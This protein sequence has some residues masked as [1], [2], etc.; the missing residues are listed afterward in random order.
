MSLR[1]APSRL[2]EYLIL[3]LVVFA[4]LLT[5]SPSVAEVD[6]WGHIQY[7]R[8]VLEG[9]LP[10]STT[11][12][13]TAAGFPWINHEN[14][15]EIALAWTADR[16]GNLGLLVGKMLL[17]LLIIGIL[18]GYNL[19]Q[20]NGWVASSVITLLVA[21]NLGFHFSLRPQVAS[22]VCFTF[23]I[24]IL[25]IAFSGWRDRWWATFSRMPK[26]ESRTPSQWLN[27]QSARLK[28]LWLIPWIM[29]IW[30]N[31]HG[32]FPA[33]LLIF[34]VYLGVRGLEAAW[35]CGWA[36]AG[37]LRRLALMGLAAALATT[38]NPYSYQ[39]HLWLWEAV[40]Y[41][42][43]E[44]SDWC[45][46]ELW[47]VTGFKFWLLLGVALVSLIASRR[48]WDVAQT[49][50]LAAVLC[51]ALLHFRHVPFFAILCG[52]W[53]GPHLRAA[54]DRLAPGQSSAS[55]PPFRFERFRTPLN[56]ALVGCGIWLCTGLAGRLNFLPVDKTKFPVAAFQFMADH[57]LNGRMVVTYDWAQYALYAFCT[58]DSLTG[59]RGSVSF[60]GRYR[61]CYPYELCD[62]HFD[63][64]FGNRPGVPRFRHPRSLPAD[65]VRIL[66]IGDPELV[67]NRR[68][69]E[70]TERVMRG[71]QQDWVLLYQDA[72]AQVWGRRSIYDNPR[73]A[74]YLAPSNRCIHDEWDHGSVAWP[75]LPTPGRR[76]WQPADERSVAS[77]SNAKPL[78]DLPDLAS[79]RF[80]E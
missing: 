45:M 25:Q 9:G 3:A 76:T 28:W 10:T 6:L 34:L 14:L 80:Q 30:A 46:N 61:T 5:I 67:I 62:Y 39:M 49:L 70:Q 48:S 69:G 11:Y 79:R 15:P 60:D 21:A 31:S 16:F 56:W 43:P 75:A 35:Q 17:G 42:C 40:G 47:T 38:L 27:Y 7:G 55:G 74:R 44:I 77:E 51:Q 57:R 33:G 22:F 1:I 54:L 37:L 2:T 13:F 50:I 72:I 68:F 41:P 59:S 26:E 19:R 23:L 32:G 71:E 53:C 24:L 73:N 29:A 36:S 66:S 52:F 58:S 78:P 18:L 65:S 12:S 4:S 64:L 8:D 63:F 20:G